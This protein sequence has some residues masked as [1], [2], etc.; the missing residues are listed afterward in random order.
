MRGGNV[1]WKDI[2][3]LVPKRGRKRNDK[4]LQTGGRG[5]KKGP[6]QKNQQKKNSHHVGTEPL[7]YVIHDRG[8]CNGAL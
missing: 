2:V 4:V 5:E 6:S 3:N 7:L 8:L 1:N